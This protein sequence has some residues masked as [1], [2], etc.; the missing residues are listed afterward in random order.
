MHQENEAREYVCDFSGCG[1]KFKRGSHLKRHLISHTH[2]KNFK[3]LK[4]IMSF[5]YKHHLDRHI[6]LV[7]DRELFKCQECN[8]EFMKKKALAKHLANIHQIKNK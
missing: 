2:E 6:K 4:C 7:H 8:M 3:C 1:K 5:G